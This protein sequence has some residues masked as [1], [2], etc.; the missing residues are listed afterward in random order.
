MGHTGLGCFSNLKKKKER[1]L[2]EGWG[3]LV[4]HKELES[5]VFPCDASEV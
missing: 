3:V 1:L 5:Q 2:K 4:L